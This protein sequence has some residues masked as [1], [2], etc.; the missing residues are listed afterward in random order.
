[1]V[2]LQ[3]CTNSDISFVYRMIHHRYSGLSSQITSCRQLEL[4]REGIQLKAFHP[5]GTRSPEQLAREEHLRQQE[6]VEK[7]RQR[8][9]QREQRQDK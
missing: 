2:L 3:L 4:E 5:Y 1:M 7:L 9:S 6:E 8:A